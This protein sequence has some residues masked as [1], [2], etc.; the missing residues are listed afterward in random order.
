MHIQIWDLRNR[1]KCC[2]WLSYLTH[3]WTGHYPRQM[4]C[5]NRC[6]ILWY[7][8]SVVQYVKAP[9]CCER[10]LWT[11]ACVLYIVPARPGPA[12]IWSEEWGVRSDSSDYSSSSVGAGPHHSLHTLSPSHWTHQPW[13]SEHC[14]QEIKKLEIKTPVNMYIRDLQ[15]DDFEI[16]L[17]VQ[18]K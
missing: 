1:W 4:Q 6:G 12:L 2:G 10:G 15:E 8:G 11:V 3:G 18:I 14:K 9:W 5:R 7:C 16:A 13:W 17:K